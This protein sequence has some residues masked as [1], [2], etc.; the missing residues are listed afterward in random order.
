L[1]LLRDLSLEKPGETAGVLILGMHRSGTSCLAGMLANF[2]LWMGDVST[3]DGGNEKG[4]QES[5]LIRDVNEAL[6]NANGGAWDRPVEVARV[7]W[8]LRARAGQLKT[9]LSRSPATWG[10]KDPRTLL[11]LPLWSDI[12]TYYVGTFRHPDAVIASLSRRHPERRSRREWE[13]VWYEYN[14]RMIDLYRAKPFPIVDF[15]WNADRYRTAVRNIAA[16]LGLKN[17]DETFFSEELRRQR[18]SGEIEN[19]VLRAAYRELLEI[20]ETE[21]KR[22]ASAFG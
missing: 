11:C 10:M 8:L 18:S 5:R 12:E 4:N 1:N 14:R 3:S 7:P 19:P 22:L 21:E 13:N 20:A 15:D 16:W 6:L 17:H 2:G 9:Q